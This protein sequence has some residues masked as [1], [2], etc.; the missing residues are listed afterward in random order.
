MS[1][2]FDPSCTAFAGRMSLPVFDG[3]VP[4]EDGSGGTAEL[5]QRI[6]VLE[7]ELAIERSRGPVAVSAEELNSLELEMER[8]YNAQLAVDLE[9]RGDVVFF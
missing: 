6:H 2:V 5:R 3:R 4:A 9:V 7:A 1:A 8:Q